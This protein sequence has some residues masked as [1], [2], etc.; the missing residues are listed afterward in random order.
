MGKN[1]GGIPDAIKEIID[2]LKEDDFDDDIEE[3]NKDIVSV[4]EPVLLYGAGVWGGALTVEQINRLHTIQRVFLLKLLRPY[5]TTATQ[6]L[7]VLSGIP[8]LHLKANYEYLKF[9]IWSCRSRG[10]AGTI[11]LNN[12]DHY[13]LLSDIPLDVRVLNLPERL[14]DNIF[15]VYTDES[16][17]AGGVEFSVCILNK[18]NQQKT[19]CHKLEPNN[20]VFQ[21]ELSADWAIQNNTKINIFT[22]SKSSIDALKSHRTKSNFIKSIKNKFRLAETLVGLTWVKAHAG[23]PGNEL[24]DQFAELATTNGELMN[25]PLPYSYLKL[26]LKRLLLQSWNDC[27]TEYQSASVTRV[28]VYV[29]RVDEKNVNF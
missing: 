23:I 19:I 13:L 24:A 10:L 15:E 8:P 27:Y 4:I 21:A 12:L 7:S 22:D 2:N 29:P 6:A 20:T 16:K 18:E 11:E 3:E 14:D 9:Q 5:R 1:K 17:I 26:Q 25:L 28:R